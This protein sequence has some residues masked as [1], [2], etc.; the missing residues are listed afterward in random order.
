VIE[1]L[2]GLHPVVQAL[3]AT[4][5]TWGVTALGAALVFFTL[6]VDRASSTR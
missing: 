3:T 1:A 6:K 2:A 5:F 4:G